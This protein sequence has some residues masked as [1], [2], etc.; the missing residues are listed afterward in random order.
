MKATA[1]ENG[2]EVEAL[3]TE[4]PCMVGTPDGEYCAEADMWLVYF[5][6]NKPLVLTDEQF[7]SQ[8]TLV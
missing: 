2:Q 3:Q 4:G 6:G 7:D 1:N 8:F 5:P